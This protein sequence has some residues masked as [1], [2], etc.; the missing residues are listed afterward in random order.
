M[1]LDRGP[2]RA[3]L[4]D[5]LITVRAGDSGALFLRGECGIG[6]TTLLNWAAGR[7]TGCRVIRIAGVEAE[8]ELAFA[9]LHRICAP[10]PD[11]LA[12]LPG[13]QRE[14]LQ[15]ALGL[16]AG[17]PPDRFLIGLGVLGLLTDLAQERPVVCLVDDVQWLDRAS[18]QVLG[19]VARR[20]GDGPVAMLFA[21]RGPEVD[22]EL[23]DLAG[24]PELPIAGLS[25]DEAR[26]VLAATDHPGPVDDRVLDRLIAECRGNPLA[27]AELPRGFTPAE[28]AGGFGL[29]GPASVPRRIQQSYRRQVAALPPAARAVLLVAAADPT[30]DPVLVWRA[31]ARLGADPDGTAA[32]ELGANGLADFDA[33]VRFRH[34]LL[35][36]A[37]YQSAAPEDR[38]RAHAALAEVTDAATDPDRR[39][40]HRAQA[41]AGPD[42]EVAAELE[43]R[44]DQAA[45][46]GGPAAAAAFLER[47]AG[48]TPDPVR[49]GRRFVQAARAEHRAG[50]PQAASRLLA[51]G[52]TVPS[53]DADLLRAH[54]AVAAGP[55]R[56][57]PG[58]LVRAADRLRPTNA[59]LA[60][61]TYL[62]ALRAAWHTGDQALVREVAEAV[63]LDD[64]RLDGLVL[65]HTAGFAAAGPGLRALI[66]DPSP[67]DD[68]LWFACSA[69][70]DLFD[71]D[72]ADRLSAEYLRR[73]R[74]TGDQAALPRARSL[75]AT[76]LALTG[77]FT[78]SGRHLPAAGPNPGGRNP[79]DRGTADELGDEL[80]DAWAGRGEQ[81]CGWARAVRANGD[82][83]YAEALDAARSAL[84]PGGPERGHLT[85]GPAFE[86]VVAAA[87]LGEP[88][89]AKE[90]LDRLAE[91]TQ[92]GGVD[93]A[94]GLEACARALLDDGPGAE[95]GFREA[96]ARLGRTRK[97]G[98]LA[99]AHLHLGEWLWGQG[100]QAQAGEQL[101]LA[102][103]VGESIGMSGFGTRPTPVNG[104]LSGQEARIVRL[105]RDGLSNAEIGA[106][107]YLS[108]RTVEWHLGKIF[109]KLGVTSRHQLRARV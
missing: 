15:V 20:L 88:V 63:R 43:Q 28:L 79:A 5:L 17:D 33:G 11:R 16:G 102:A 39:A 1:L 26:R 95:G 108:P 37:V 25:D 84:G 47:A 60:R 107:L 101:R 76:A 103:E 73:A 31:V 58:L 74:A 67:A 65:R 61:T 90:A 83:R 51:M 93:G 92:A 106:R 82:G 13:P 22:G 10:E 45:S 86:L 105:V 53:D 23:P 18:A 40:W 35:R 91:L 29:L 41:A 36:S 8:R 72:A 81:T 59:A 14:A 49:R 109:G 66:A 100:R 12:R 4:D 52:S 21:A 38:R 6:K 99:R 77:D 54:L 78:G 57:A 68:V 9:A 50:R 75:R 46:R 27:L 30:G 104:L 98:F 24:V 96:V 2:E 94:L 56:D 70:I 3:A 89:A 64:P 34:P 48:L 55:G 87:H 7:A 85:W 32:A 97:K 80:A 42:E 19:F 62:D 71:D 44:A 69:A